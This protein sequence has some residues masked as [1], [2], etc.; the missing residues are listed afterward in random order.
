MTTNTD[1]KENGNVYN[2]NNIYEYLE[3]DYWDADDLNFD[4]WFR[5]QRHQQIFYEVMKR[6]NIK[7]GNVDNSDDNKNKI[8]CTQKLLEEMKEKNKNHNVELLWDDSDD[9]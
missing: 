6:N 5:L 8:D 4:F 1:Y 9:E 3:K 7:L 2:L